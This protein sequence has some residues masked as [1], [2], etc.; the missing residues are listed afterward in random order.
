MA[1]SLN[2][3]PQAP[4]ISALLQRELNDATAEIRTLKEQLENASTRFQQ[5]IVLL[6]NQM[7]TQMEMLERQLKQQ[8]DASQRFSIS[9]YIQHHREASTNKRCEYWDASA[10][11]LK[12][13]YGLATASILGDHSTLAGENKK[14]ILNS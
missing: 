14:V 2:T 10:S 3:A 7:K 4:P 5:Q 9:M 1:N 12:K 6:K 13:L 8:Q 11:I